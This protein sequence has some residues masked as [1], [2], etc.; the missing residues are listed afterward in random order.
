M[1]LEM[2]AQLR[3]PEDIFFVGIKVHVIFGMRERR[4]LNVGADGSG[5]VALDLALELR[6][7]AFDAAVVTRKFAAASADV[8]RVAA[9]EF[10]FA[11]IFQILPARHPGDR[12]VGDVVGRRRLAKQPR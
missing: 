7:E 6:A 12:G 8:E 3:Y 5:I 11:R 2:K 10:L 4:G 9:E 1:P